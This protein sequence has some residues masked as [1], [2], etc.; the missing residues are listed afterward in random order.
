MSEERPPNL[1]PRRKLDI[2]Q[3]IGMG[4][5]AQRGAVMIYALITVALV[6]VALYMA[7]IEQRPLMS[8]WVAA[9]AIGA[10]WFGLRLFMILG[11]RR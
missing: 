2:E 5:V 4:G 6:A 3:A 10:L 11:S 1:P 8:G 7:L 9:P